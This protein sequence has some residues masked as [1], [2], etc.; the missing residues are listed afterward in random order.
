MATKKPDIASLVQE[1]M[2]GRDLSLG[3]D[4]YQ[5]EA[6]RTERA[7]FTK[8]AKRAVTVR[9]DE[10]DYQKLQRIA[11]LQGTSAA[12]LLRQAAKG[13]IKTGNAV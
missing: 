13:I 12:A 10:G 9:F 4:S 3:A 6:G 2:S 5:E 11:A 1:S 7:A 8:P